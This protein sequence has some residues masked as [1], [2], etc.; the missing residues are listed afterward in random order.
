MNDR[1]KDIVKTHFQT[2][3]N[4]DEVIS[5]EKFRRTW[6]GG[7]GYVQYLRLSC[8]YKNENEPDQSVYKDLMEIDRK[9]GITDYEQFC[10]LLFAP[11]QYDLI[12]VSCNIEINITFCIIFNGLNLP[13]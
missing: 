1:A 8:S 10:V 11:V 4:K 13:T 6:T 5:Y 3:A 2:F 7:L 12:K 9:L